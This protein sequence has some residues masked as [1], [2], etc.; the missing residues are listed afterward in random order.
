MKCET[1][2]KTYKRLFCVNLPGNPQDIMII[3]N[4][5]YTLDSKSI[6]ALKQNYNYVC[7]IS[8][9]IFYNKKLL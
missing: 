2:N 9:G 1:V 6:N 5:P 7:C 3:N 4:H 8:Y